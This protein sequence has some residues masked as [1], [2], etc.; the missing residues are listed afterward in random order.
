MKCLDKDNLKKYFE[1]ALC[2]SEVFYIEKDQKVIKKY[3][4]SIFDIA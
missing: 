3:M 2:I 1:Y 4:Q